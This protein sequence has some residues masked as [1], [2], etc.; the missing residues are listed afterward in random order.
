MCHILFTDSSVFPFGNAGGVFVVFQVSPK[1][2]LR[3]ML[4]PTDHQPLR[5]E[6]DLSGIVCYV[7]YR[8]LTEVW[9][10]DL[11]GSPSIFRSKYKR[12][13]LCPH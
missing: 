4:V 3:E 7:I 1:S 5:L 6:L 13:L 12:A 10:A 9:S 2:K 8:A 11:P